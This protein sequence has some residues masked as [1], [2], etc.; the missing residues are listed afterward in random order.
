MT[1]FHIKKHLLLWQ[2]EKISANRDICNG[3]LL[4]RGI[5]QLINVTSLRS[6]TAVTVAST[7]AAVP[8]T[9]SYCVNVS[10]DER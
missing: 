7:A 9:R 2:F 6:A 4:H 3:Y 8:S 5:L 1:W 10:S